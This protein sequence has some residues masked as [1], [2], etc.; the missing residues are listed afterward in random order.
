MLRSLMMANGFEALFG[1]SVKSTEDPPAAVRARRRPPSAQT[2]ILSFI[3]PQYIPAWNKQPVPEKVA[4]LAT[5]IFHRARDPHVRRVCVDARLRMLERGRR[6]LETYLN[7]GRTNGLA[8]ERLASPDSS[9]VR[10]GFVLR[11]WRLF[12]WGLLHTGLREWQ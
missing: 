3:C 7:F 4:L 12:E 11:Q 10:L 9:L 6:V 8:A 2:F 5:V 1:V